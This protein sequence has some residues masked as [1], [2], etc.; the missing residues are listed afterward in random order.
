MSASAWLR[1]VRAGTLFSPASDVIAG[2]ALQGTPWSV[3]LLR[4]AA[5]SV[6]VYAGGMVLNDHADRRE[7][8]LQRPER[9]IPSGDLTPA[10]AHGGGLLLLV[11]GV[12]VAPWHAWW[13]L[14]AVL[15]LTYDYVAKRWLVVAAPLMGSLRALNLLG[16]AWFATQGLDAID[17][18]L[19]IPV[20]CY[21]LY[22]LA[23]TLLG[24]LEDE[25]KIAPRAVVGVQSVPPLVGLLALFALPQRGPAVLIGLALTVLFFAR[26]RRRGMD[27]PRAAIRGSM[28]WLLLGTMAFTSLLCLGS[29]RPWEAVGIAAAIVPARWISRSI[30]LT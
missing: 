24:A 6:L 5:A 7:D 20:L 22:V 1:L 25:P 23:V 14:L 18:E 15:V 8:A 10:A 26:M 29:G 30:A 4:A 17:V 3:E 11:A 9:P 16:G 19:A 28:T 27:W 21:G 2:A 12:A 13:A